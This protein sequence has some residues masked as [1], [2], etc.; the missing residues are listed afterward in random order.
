M[1]TIGFPISTKENEKRRCLIPK[2][3]PSIKNK[4]SMYIETGYGNVLGFTDEDYS[5]E[6][7]N[8]ITKEEVLKKDIICDPKIG[9]A[10]YL[11]QL[12]NQ[13]VFGW[14]H[15][16]QNKN[17]TDI[18][19]NN[20]ITAYAW[21]DMYES[22]RHVFWRNNEIAGEAAIMH[23]YNLYGLFPYN[24]KVAILGRGNVS[25]GALKILTLLGADIMVYTRQMEQLFR[26]E[27]SKYDV[28]VNA[29]LWDTS[30]KDHIIYKEDLKKMK[31]GALIIDISCDRNGG[32]ETCIPTTIDNP[33]YVIDGITHYAVD[34]TPSLFYKTISESLS[35]IMIMYIDDLIE[36][37]L[38]NDILNKSLIID[39]GKIIDQRIISFQN[40][41]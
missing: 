21:E 9:D 3:I 17:I 20:K 11:S 22:G 2:H 38:N 33:T 24:T 19:V 39:H 16:V 25:R 6:G 30:R 41:K 23:A 34:H 27:I 4:K 8:V 32:I 12:N 10:E 1:K 26:K 40:R 15:A 28:I 5:R 31:K 29:I 36:G 13:I 37:N 7:V 14:V 35:E 18:M